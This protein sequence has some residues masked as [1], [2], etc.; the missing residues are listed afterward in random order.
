MILRGNLG[1]HLGHHFCGNDCLVGVNGKRHT[2]FKIITLDHMKKMKNNAE[3]R[4]CVQHRQPGPFLGLRPGAQPQAPPHGGCGLTLPFGESEVLLAHML[5]SGRGTIT[6]A[7]TPSQETCHDNTTGVRIGEASHP[8]P[9]A[10]KATARRR[11]QKQQQNNLGQII[12]LLLPLLTQLLQVLDTGRATDSSSIPSLTT[13]LGNPLGTQQCTEPGHTWQ[14]SIAQTP[15]TS[16]DY[17]PSKPGNTPAAQPPHP[18]RPLRGGQPVQQ[19]SQPQ[20]HG[21]SSSTTR[22]GHHSRTAKVRPPLANRKAKGPAHQAHRAHAAHTTHQQHSQTA[23]SPRSG[24]PS[25]VGDQTLTRGPSDPK[26]GATPLS[27]TT[28]WQP[29]SRSTL[30]TN[31]FEQ[32]FTAATMNKDKQQQPCSQHQAT[33]CLD[34]LSTSRRHNQ[35]PW[36]MRQQAVTTKSGQ[37]KDC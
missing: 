32:S 24:P 21:A 1:I 30:G 19:Y 11:Q 17:L 7:M 34:P 22:N 25:L 15:Q 6:L 2:N 37:H 23:A 20:Q 33:S 31:P 5:T 8:G 26:T 13:A 9:A 10:A 28:H 18:L 36:A 4:H 29:L 16:G 27:T 14:T 3:Q 12:N 35:H